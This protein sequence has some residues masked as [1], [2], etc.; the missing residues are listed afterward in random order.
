MKTQAINLRF[1]FYLSKAVFALN[2]PHSRNIH[3]LL[4]IGSSNLHPSDK[5]SGR[6]YTE[7]GAEKYP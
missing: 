4:R 1:C 6:K 2:D 7:V 3:I 5:V